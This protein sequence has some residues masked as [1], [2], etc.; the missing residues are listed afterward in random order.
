M[1]KFPV[2]AQDKK[3]QAPSRDSQYKSQGN[4]KKRAKS[5]AGFLEKRQASSSAKRKHPTDQD[6]LKVLPIKIDS[7]PQSKA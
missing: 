6:H 4:K 7:I 2:C 5:K 3:A 1:L